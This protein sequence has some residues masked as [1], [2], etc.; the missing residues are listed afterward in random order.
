[1]GR[2]EVS[3]PRVG[4]GS[5][6]EPGPSDR[7]LGLDE[8]GRGSLIGPLVVGGFVARRSD[9]PELIRLGVRDSKLLSPQRRS[10]LYG[11]LTALGGCH[12][13]A[14]SPRT[15]DRHVRRH[16]LNVLEAQAFADLLCEAAPS[17]AFVDA[18]DV[19]ADRFGRTIVRMARTTVPVYAR[20]EADR[21]V[22]V[23]SAA[24]IIAKVRRD[25]AVARIRRAV[26]TD[27]GSGYPGDERTRAF[28]ERLL[29]RPV[30][31]PTWLRESWSTTKRMRQEALLR[32]LESFPP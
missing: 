16:G 18:C 20:H 29:R 1:M 28:V 11:A 23:V 7:I 24:S 9:L 3:G 4:V 2:R 25:R 30:R 5:S 22:P 17:E 27:F 21:F 12:S 32:P 31:S 13:I 10:E 6:G 14:L 8:A 15:I 26:G 19:D